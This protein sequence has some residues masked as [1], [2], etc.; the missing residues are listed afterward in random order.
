M[1]FI[2]GFGLGLLFPMAVRAMMQSGKPVALEAIRGGLAKEAVGEEPQ[3]E[4]EPPAEEPET[5]ATGKQQTAS[6]K[7]S[8]ASGGSKG[9]SKGQGQK[10]VG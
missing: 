1:R 9:T 7:Q 3:K 4:A 8:P 5:P 2:L 6:A 10:K